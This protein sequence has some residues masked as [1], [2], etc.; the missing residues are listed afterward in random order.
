MSPQIKKIVAAGWMLVFTRRPRVSSPPPPAG[1]S[2]GKQF[3]A[4]PKNIFGPVD[5]KKARIFFI[6]NINPR[7]L[8]AVWKGSIRITDRQTVIGELQSASYLCWDREPGET[9]V[10]F[11]MPGHEY[12][13]GWYVT[14]FNTYR[15]NTESGQSYYLYFSGL[16]QRSI[17]LARDAAALLS[18]Y[19]PPTVVN[20]P[21]PAPASAPVS[22]LPANP[23]PTESSTAQKPM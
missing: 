15:I 16:A 13:N 20:E 6:T 10:K 23:T 7:I 19:P 11:T 9:V 14:H 1:I 8:G 2:A 5:A 4:V 17:L 3:V 18:T 12:D 22:A 21:A